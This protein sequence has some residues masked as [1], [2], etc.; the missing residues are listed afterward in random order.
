MKSLKGLTRAVVVSIISVLIFASI[1]VAAQI[2]PATLNYQGVLTDTTGQSLTGQK[3]IVVKLYTSQT[4]GSAFWS[5]SY[6]VTLKNGQFSV[7][8]GSDS[9]PLPAGSFTGTTYIGVQVN[10]EAEMT[11][12]QKMAS[13]AYALM[14]H[15]VSDTSSI[16]PAGSIIAYGGSTAPAGW[17]LCNGNAVSR[18]TYS[19]L[20]AA[21][22]TA[23]GSGNGSSTFNLPDYQGRFLRGVANSST[24]DPDS[25]SRTAM[26]TGGNPGNQVGSVQGDIFRSHNHSSNMAYHGGNGDGSQPSL[27][28]AGVGEISYGAGSIGNKD[29]SSSAGGNETRPVNAYVNWIIKY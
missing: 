28:L 20:F 10:S 26:S 7:V 19:A 15:S 1:G 11:P 3:T 12:R 22:G 23:H 9:N 21:I 4:G 6:T 18:T 16:V 2:E 27:Y 8:L 14:A 24:L 25:A 29:V 13:V 17:L 5:D